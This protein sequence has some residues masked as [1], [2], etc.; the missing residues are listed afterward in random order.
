M[1]PPI[2]CELGGVEA[3]VVAW[4]PDQDGGLHSAGA[5]KEFRINPC[6]GKKRERE[7]ERERERESL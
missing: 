5:L 7:G 1:T 3:A 2:R 6:F 4:L